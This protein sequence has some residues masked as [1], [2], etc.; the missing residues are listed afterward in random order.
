MKTNYKNKLASVLFL[1]G[2][3]LIFNPIYSQETKKAKVCS[4]TIAVKKGWNFLVEPYFMFPNMS[5]TV[6]LG[7]L[8]D[9]TFNADPSD[10]LG[11]LH[12]GAMLYL[13]AGNEKWNVNSDLLYMNLSEGIDPTTLIAN[14]EV[15]A[16]QLGFEV[17]GLYKITPSIQVGIGELINSIESEVN[18]NRN[19]IGGGTT[20]ISGKISETWTDLLIVA[21]FVNKPGQR[22]LYKLR[23][24]IG[25]FGI[26]GDTNTAWQVQGYA[27]Y[28]F[29]E[30]FQLTA[31]YRVIGLNYATGT[32]SDRFVYDVDTYGGVVRLGFNF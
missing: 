13:E 29:S 3:M 7:N 28:R 9:V 20:N 16:K 12:M 30:L 15:K 23:G 24:E 8:P 27:G 5:G 19:V 18:I 6:G 14:G 26:S 21:S 1:V 10:I 25:G 2:A 31:G 17:A 4:D 22:F 11:N 32:G